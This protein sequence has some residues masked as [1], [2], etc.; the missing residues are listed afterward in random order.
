MISSTSFI[1]HADCLNHLPLIFVNIA[2]PGQM[3]VAASNPPQQKNDRTF[4]SSPNMHEIV[5]T[6]LNDLFRRTG[7]KFDMIFN[8]RRRHF[9]NCL[10]PFERHDRSAR[11]IPQ[12]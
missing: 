3:F 5:L 1:E 7:R 9:G 10:P 2:V 12:Q 4:I 11:S 6:V 8:V